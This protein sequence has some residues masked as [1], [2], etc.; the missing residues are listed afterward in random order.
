M[1]PSRELEMPKARNTH[2]FLRSLY[3]WL[4]TD[5]GRSETE[6]WGRLTR[7]EVTLAKLLMRS[8][9]RKVG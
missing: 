4:A 7:D 3:R 9:F 8:Y 2:D 6:F 5:E 1:T